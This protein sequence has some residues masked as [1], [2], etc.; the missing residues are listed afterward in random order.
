MA[1]SPIREVLAA[2]AVGK[3]HARAHPSALRLPRPPILVSGSRNLWRIQVGF[4]ICG[5][6]SDGAA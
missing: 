3:T 1:R 6:E 4:D 2:G 5:P